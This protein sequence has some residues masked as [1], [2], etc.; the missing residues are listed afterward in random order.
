MVDRVAALSRLTIIA[1][2]SR[3]D[4]ALPVDMSL[5][6][7]LPTLL[8]NAGE[9]LPDAGLKHGGWVLQRLGEQ[10]FDTGKSLAA[11]GVRDGEMLYFRPRDSQLPEFAF[12]DVVDAIATATKDRQNA[13]RPRA[14]R[15][16]GLTFAIVAIEL[17]AVLTLLSGPDWHAPGVVAGAVAVALVV[18]G[19]ILSRVVGDAGAGAALGYAAL[20]YAFVSGLVALGGQR[21]LLEFGAAQL[22]SAL[23]AVLLAAVL[24]AFVVA[25]G[26]P[27]F[28]G[29]AMA[30]GSGALG[31]LLSLLTGLDAAG[32]A[33]VTVTALLAVTPLIPLASSRL[34][35]LPLP[36]I[37]LNAD[38]LRTDQGAVP[39][40][41][42]LAKTT[43]ADRF[44]TGLVGGTA[45]LVSGC[46]VLLA[47]AG[48]TAPYFIAVVGGVALLRA[49]LFHGRGQRACLLAAGGFA[50]AA[51]A[52][53]VAA[54]G[55]QV[56]RL[57]AV[58]LPLLVTAAATV[59]L[60][61]ALPGRR[62]SPFWGRAGD[63]A[64]SV[65]VISLVPLVLSVLGL[66]GFVRGLGG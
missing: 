55:D 42:V 2:A 61:H 66:Y 13:W 53:E 40:A 27:G 46:V 64:E 37:P 47:P 19:G 11:L 54:R 15:L 20:P 62:L 29:A 43:V 1:P 58:L 33:S 25:D 63:I 23:A 44:V 32:G 4:V 60:A 14:T 38:D 9:D 16:A 5:A 28:L 17:G 52:W 10:P 3:L 48:G 57:L 24:A 30:A 31:A 21:G 41:A 49:R 34:A 39:G 65:L 59:T 18:A 56:V 45:A 7:L 50:F 51:L 12:D 8:R 36:F 22:L 6:E 35:G 26:M